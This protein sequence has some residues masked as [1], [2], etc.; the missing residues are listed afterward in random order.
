[1]QIDKKD[2]FMTALNLSQV[3][4]SNYSD[5]VNQGDSIYNSRHSHVD[6]LRGDDKIIGTTKVTDEF[7]IYVGIKATK[8]MSAIASAEWKTK[9]NVAVY[10]INNEGSIKTNDGNDLI[11]GKATADITA[12]AQTVSEVIAVARKTNATAIAQTFASINVKATADGI[13]NSSGVIDTEQGGDTINGD[14]EASISAIALAT[15]K[16]IAEAPVSE[17]LTAF[18]K[19][20]AI[21]FAQ[22]NIIA[23]GIKNSGGKIITGDGNDT[24]NASATSSASTFAGGNGVTLASANSENKALAQAVL[25]ATAK[26]TDTAIAIDNSKG[27]IDTGWGNDTI[28]AKASGSKSYGIL[29]G[30]IDT[31]YGDDRIIASSFG[32]GVNIDLGTGNDF[33]QGFGDAKLDGALGWDTLDLSDYNKDNFKISFGGF[34]GF[35][36]NNSVS[37]KLDGITLT[38]TS[39][40]QFNFANGSYSFDQLRSA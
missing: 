28:I 30:N 1:M 25:S 33:V 34:F 14:A 5:V 22:G 17:G 27:R 11:K 18:A 15:A 26:A 23:T 31:G 24:I 2:G 10:G 39:F 37:F 13:D 9:A 12:A 6:T 8:G 4:F 40:E 29:G 20:I 32:G 3:R 7:G 19:A 21:S 35:S 36:L 16:A 38:T